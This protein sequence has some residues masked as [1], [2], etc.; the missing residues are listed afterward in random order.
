MQ[1][2]ELNTLGDEQDKEL[3]FIDQEPEGLDGF[4]YRLAEGAPT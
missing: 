4:G 2:F 3:V 1:Y